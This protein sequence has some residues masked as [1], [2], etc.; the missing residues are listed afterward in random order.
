MP[1]RRFA[2]RYALAGVNYQQNICQPNN[3]ALNSKNLCHT[4]K[5]LICHNAPIL[6]SLI[7]LLHVIFATFDKSTNS[8]TQTKIHRPWH[9]CIKTNLKLIYSR[10]TGGEPELITSSFCMPAVPMM[11]LHCTAQHPTTNTQALQ[12]VQC[13]TYC[14]RH[15]TPV[16][17]A[18]WLFHTGAVATCPGHNSSTVSVGSICL[19]HV[20]VHLPTCPVFVD[21]LHGRLQHPHQY[22]QNARSIS[23]HRSQDAT[24]AG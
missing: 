15:K 6:H 11:S 24:N 9:I 14:E 1:S 22:T 18:H 12:Q 4:T 3:N 20:S 2:A 7:L 10:N 13:H 16:Q 23:G 17:S 19:Y 21:N 8:H 5:C